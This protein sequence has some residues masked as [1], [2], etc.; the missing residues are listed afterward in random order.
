[1]LEN[2]SP[3]AHF[4]ININSTDQSAFSPI[5][6]ADEVI[7]AHCQQ[8]ASKNTLSRKGRSY[9]FPLLKLQLW[10]SVQF[11]N[12]YSLHLGPV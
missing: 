11:Q 5:I 9:T 10:I 1:M 8:R 2:K 4:H 6:K 3:D 7:G 12:N